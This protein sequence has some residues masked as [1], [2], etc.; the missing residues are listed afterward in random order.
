MQ[1]N[2]QTTLRASFSAA[3]G[4]KNTLISVIFFSIKLAVVIIALLFIYYKVIVEHDLTNI[5]L[6]YEKLLT[7]VPFLLLTLALALVTVNWGLEAWK[8]KFTLRK[9]EKIDLY[10]SLRGVLSGVTVS[11]A[12]PNR[13]GEFAGRIIHLEKLNKGQAAMLAILTSIS[14]LAVTIVAGSVGATVLVIYYPQVLPA[15]LTYYLPVVVVSAILSLFIF[16]NLNKLPVIFKLLLLKKIIPFFNIL[17]KLSLYDMIIIFL[18]S[19]FR[20]LIF[21]LQF[22]LLLLISDVHIS[23]ILAFCLISVVYFIMT[24]IPTTIISEL[25]VRGSVSVA[26]IGLASPDTLAIV[27][28]GF[29]LWMINLMIPALLGTVFLFKAKLIKS[30]ATA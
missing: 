10:K 8:W 14:Q 27:N 16:F 15:E 29:I 1:V 13:T 3:K 9:F 7:V 17:K 19:V 12:A 6:H 11:I 5:L 26:I 22:Y 20:Y 24:F 18:L 28:A 2:L 30:P 4:I 25:A 21:S 23:I